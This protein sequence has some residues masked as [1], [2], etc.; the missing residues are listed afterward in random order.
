MQAATTVLHSLHSFL[1]LSVAEPKSSELTEKRVLLN[2]LRGRRAEC[3][4]WGEGTAPE[5]RDSGTR[6]AFK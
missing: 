2:S 4:P 1:P 5:A 3:E 6:W